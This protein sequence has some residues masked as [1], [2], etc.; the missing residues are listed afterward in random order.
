MSISFSTRWTLAVLLASSQAVRYMESFR[1][2]WNEVNVNFILHA[3]DLGSPIG[4]KPSGTIHG[5]LQA[6]MKWSYV[7]FGD[8]VNVRINIL[9]GEMSCYEGHTLGPFG[10]LK[11]SSMRFKSDSQVDPPNRSFKFITAL[12]NSSLVATGKTD[13]M[14][15]YGGK[16]RWNKWR[17]W[18]AI[19]E[20]ARMENTAASARDNW[21]RSGNCGRKMVQFHLACNMTQ[22]PLHLLVPVSHKIINQHQEIVEGLVIL[23]RCHRWRHCRHQVTIIDPRKIICSFVVP[24]GIE[25]SCMMSLS[26]N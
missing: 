4:V 9:T 8:R 25:T 17:R 7:E 20:G 1:P 21:D 14:E 18:E 2:R 3:L 24:R 15:G 6:T 11:G 16:K 13:F 12:W 22:S 26:S 10:S 5:V 23:E 19:I